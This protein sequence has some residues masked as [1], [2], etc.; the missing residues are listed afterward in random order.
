MLPLVLTIAKLLKLHPGGS[1]YTFASKE[2]NI[3]TG[4]FEPGQYSYKISIKY[5]NDSFFFINCMAINTDIGFYT[6]YYFD[7]LIIGFF[8][9]LNMFNQKAGTRIQ[10][11]FMLLKNDTNLICNFKWLISFYF[12]KHY[13]R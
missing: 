2:I 12:K 5:F 8:T 10:F 4:F 3:E 1:F 6:Y 11:M 9:I 13:C 7:I